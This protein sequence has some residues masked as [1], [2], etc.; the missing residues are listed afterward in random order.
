VDDRIDP[1]GPRPPSAAP[2]PVIR[3]SD[4]STEKRQ[5]DDAEKRKRRPV[6]QPAPPPDDGMPHIDVR[7]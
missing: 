5:R 7:V 2:I 6:P 3:R 4:G 1:I